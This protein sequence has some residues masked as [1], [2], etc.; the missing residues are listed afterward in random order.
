[1]RKALLPS[2]I[3]YV[4]QIA[5][6]GA[7]LI[8]LTVLRLT[9]TILNICKV[10]DHLMRKFLSFLAIRFWCH[11]A[12]TITCWQF[13]CCRD[14]ALQNWHQT[15]LVGERTGYRCIII[16]FKHWYN[17]SDGHL[18]KNAS[19]F[20]GCRTVFHHMQVIKS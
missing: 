6:T 7:R 3:H 17:R 18:I 15:Q 12:K 10:H 1:M 4:R 9:T 13:C 20:L 14:W 11:S 5:P 16:N 8:L 2:N 19:N